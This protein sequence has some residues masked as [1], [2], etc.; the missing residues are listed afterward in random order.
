MSILLLLVG[1]AKPPPTHH[2]AAFEALAPALIAEGVVVQHTVVV[3]DL[4][5]DPLPPLKP[6]SEIELRLRS[7][8][9][10]LGEP[11][12]IDPAN[13]A[14]ASFLRNDYVGAIR[15]GG[16]LIRTGE[17]ALETRARFIE[18]SAQGE[19]RAQAT[20]WL[21]ETTTNL[22]VGH[23][24]P[25]L[26][27]DPALSA[28]AVAR[29]AVRGANELDGSDNLNLPRIAIEPLSMAASS[30][31][32]RWVLIPYLR[33]YYVHN[34]GWF[35]GQEWGCTGGARVEAMLVVY[36][37]RTGNPAWWQAAA[38]RHVQEMKAQPSRAEMDQFL[39]WSEDQVEA[40]LAA[41]FL[42]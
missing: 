32:A 18:F 24:I 19:L 7:G 28:P 17:T 30:E 4:A 37:R 12:V 10:H 23:K 27:H 40:S 38:G 29:K 13:A 33:S 14:H 26:P 36:D 3:Q 16:G 2:G 6:P 11:T 42:K 1:C 35:L 21:D 31:G 9:E 39:L 20:A 5:S 41:G 25:A 15:F 8:E 22:V 34:G